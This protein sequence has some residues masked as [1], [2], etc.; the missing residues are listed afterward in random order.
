[1]LGRYSHAESLGHHHRRFRYR[2]PIHARASAGRSVLETVLPGC[3]RRIP[4]NAPRQTNLITSPKWYLGDTLHR[5]DIGCRCNVLDIVDGWVLAIAIHRKSTKIVRKHRQSHVVAWDSVG[6]H[7]P[8]HRCQVRRRQRFDWDV[9][10]HHRRRDCRVSRN[11][12][13]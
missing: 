13:Q 4:A 5:A 1:M 12:S 8:W 3:D 6:V 2:C 7:N 11:S 10:Q 9:R